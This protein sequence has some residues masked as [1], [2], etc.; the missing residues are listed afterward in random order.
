MS[1][2]ID[3]LL[4]P[5]L[6][7]TMMSI[8]L[9]GIM[10]VQTYIYFE[11]YKNDA[12]WIKAMVILLFILDALSS[13][14]AMSMTYEY[15]VKNFG[16]LEAI[17]VTN[18]G[19]NAYPIF[20]G[21]TACIVQCF[22][23]R[24]IDVLTERRW[25]AIS[26]AVLAN[27]QMLAGIGVG[28]GGAI[29]KRF[30]D[31]GKLKQIILVWLFGSVV[32][33][34]LITISLVL[35]LHQAKTGFPGTDHMTARI[36][37]FTVQT[38]LLTTTCALGVVMAYLISSQSTVDLAFGLPL[39]KL[40]TNSLV[41]SLNARKGWDPQESESSD[42]WQA[43]LNRDMRGRQMEF[44]TPGPS[45]LTS[46]FMGMTREFTDDGPGSEAGS[47]SKTSSDVPTSPSSGGPSRV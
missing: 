17:V 39:S 28:I 46:D 35:F 22:F 41:S 26:I 4:G 16:D 43:E 40:Y 7:G 10:V 15:L 37:R 6:I 29:V 44:N 21:L 13:A 45:T 32:T 25:L 47:C 30:S 38:G 2:S 9:F 34:A 18:I 3:L 1:R 33:D 8:L 24:R 42:N 23:A 20:T 14:F 19:I 36:I 12:T 27:F 31:L 5:V 11:R